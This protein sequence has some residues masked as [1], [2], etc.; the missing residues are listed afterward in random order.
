MTKR[1]TQE[2]VFSSIEA[3]L[4]PVRTHHSHEA[5]DENA[6]FSYERNTLKLMAILMVVWFIV[7]WL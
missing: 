3:D 6:L 1:F 2:S 7:A 5:I 4:E